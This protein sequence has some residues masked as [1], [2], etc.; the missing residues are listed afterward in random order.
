M[1]ITSTIIQK[2]YTISD[3]SQEEL[4]EI[5]L[6]VRKAIVLYTERCLRN[7]RQLEPQEIKEISKLETL[8]DKLTCV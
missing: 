8:L 6:A 7:V 1:K 3:I 5:R 2:T 4:D